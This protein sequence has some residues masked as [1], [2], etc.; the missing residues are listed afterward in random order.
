MIK[1]FSQMNVKVENLD[2][3]LN[4]EISATF[5][6]VK[7]SLFQ[8]QRIVGDIE[9][10]LKAQKA[11]ADAAVQAVPESVKIDENKPP[12]VVEQHVE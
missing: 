11:E 3:Y 9:D 6:M 10:K 2:F 8:F 4:C 7:E 12:E 1:N 5:P